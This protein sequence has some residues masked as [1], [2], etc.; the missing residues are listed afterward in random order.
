MRTSFSQSE[1]YKSCSQH[2]YWRYKEKIE[3]ND[4]GASA[5]FGS[6]VDSAIGAMLKDPTVNFYKTFQNSWDVTKDRKG[7][8]LKIFDND[9]INYAHTDFDKDVINAFIGETLPSITLWMEEL[10][11]VQE[12]IDENS[13]LDWQAAYSACSK[14]KKNPYKK[15]QPNY[16]KFFN[17]MSWLSLYYKGLLMIE[18]FEKQFYPRIEKVLAVQ[19]AA[20][21]KD[22]GTGDSISGY[23]DMILKLKDYDRPII[24]DLKTSARPYTQ[25]QIDQSE[26]LTIYLAMEGQR[27]NTDAVGYVVLSKAINK[28]A[29]C[30]CKSCNHKKDGRHKTCNAMVSKPRVNTDPGG[31]YFVEE[32][33]GGEWAETVELKPEVQVMIERKNNMQVNKVLE[34]Q[35]NI[36]H[37]MK[38]SV[39]FKNL[40]K[41][42]NW[43]GNRCSF[44]DLCHKGSDKG[45]IKDET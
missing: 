13:G 37:G 28:E 32:R 6:A 21:I 22:E 7:N 35:E 33:C 23:I 20:S 16:L 11:L 5:F 27:F 12:F 30:Y 42:N 3:T 26:Q 24:F 1:T 19:K 40:S 15:I 36:I 34:T 10:E 43:Y 18:S 31:Q 45:L 29:V 38:N 14:A 8:T 41:C 39:V 25:E 44:Y 2:W 17:R 9:S 4:T